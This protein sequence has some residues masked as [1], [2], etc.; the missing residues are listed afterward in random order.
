M[1]LNNNQKTA[2]EFD[3]HLSLVS[4]PGSGKTRTVV[5]KI[6][7]CL[8]DIRG[9]TRRIGCITYT[10][11]A[12]NEIVH[13]LRHLGAKDDDLYYEVT[14]IHSF[15]LNHVMRTNH[16]LLAEFRDGFEIITSDDDRWK[17]LVRTLLEKHSINRR[18]ADRFDNIE[19]SL[20][21]IRP[22]NEIAWTASKEFVE[23]MDRSSLV[24][25]SDIVYHSCRLISQSPT[26]ARGLAS[27][28]AWILIDE[29]QDTTEAQLQVFRA[30]A[31]YKRTKFFM[32]GD[33]NQS[34]MSFAGVNP[35]MMIEFVSSLGANRSVI[36]KSNYRCSQRIIDQ[37]ERLCPSNPPMEACGESADFLKEPEW[38]HV[39]SVTQAVFDYFIPVIDSLKISLGDAAVLSPNWFTLLGLS[40]DLRLRGIPMIGP[41]SRPYKRS[42]I[43]A[44]FAEHVC[45]YIEQ[46]DSTISSGTHRALFI[47]LLNIT[48]SADWRIYSY[49]GRKTLFRLI[50][51]AKKARQQHEG[52]A[53]W[54]RSV[55][56]TFTDRLI[57]D[58]FL[59]DDKSHI[60]LESAN[61]MIDDMVRNKVDVPNL[62]ITD[63]GLFAQPSRCLNLIT[64]HSAKGSEFDA[65]AIVDLHEGKIPNFRS[66]TYEEKA[67]ARRLLYVGVT[68]ARKVLM[69]FT[70]SSNYRNRP[71]SLL[72]IDGLRLRSIPTV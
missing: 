22:P 9:T 11:T 63:L 48:G 19:R 51:I 53:S 55:A 26:I 5:A 37:A 10:N 58:E 39:D 23:F 16:H 35:R 38:F 31:D 62:T 14:T 68:R 44:Q 60:L 46:P 54:L 41:G 27:R 24:T 70:D 13:R 65:V 72:G 30:I 21:G 36:L 32:V 34:I 43:L 28:Y 18:F 33:P 47:M 4:C 3:G 71:S 56:Q 69:Y 42:R 40:K 59:P 20:N 15:C 8:E 25:L 66:T 2:V 52:A 1:N 29:F 45:A 7:H 50:G 17:E 6:L 12:V 67:E 61:S 64:L 57:S 49:E